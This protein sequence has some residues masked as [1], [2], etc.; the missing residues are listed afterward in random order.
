MES[1][2][3]SLAAVALEVALTQVGVSEQPK[4]SNTGPEVNMYLKAVGL[5]PGFAWCMAFVYW[6]VNEAA[7]KLAVGNPLVKTAGVLKQWNETNLRKLSPVADL[8]A[9]KPGDVF[10]MEFKHGNGHTGFV[11]NVKGSNVYTIEGNT[12]DDGSREGYEVA[13]RVRN[14]KDFKGFIQLP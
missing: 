14:I 12:N 4:N 1:V 11:V 8:K 6:C 13:L 2:K 9:I 3:Q 10:I 5:K 7:A